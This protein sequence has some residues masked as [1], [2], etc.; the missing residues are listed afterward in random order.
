VKAVDLP[1]DLEED[2]SDVNSSGTAVG[3]SFNDKGEV[4]FVYVNG[5]A[6]KLAGPANGSA[7]AIN[8]AG[9]I[10]G[11][12]SVGGP[13]ATSN[14]L[15]WT[16]PT[17]KPVKLPVPAGV[18]S[19]VAGDIDEDGTTVGHLDLRTPYV[20]FPDGTHRELPMPAYQGRT[21][22]AARAFSIRNGIAIGV[23][24]ATDAGKTGTR[25]AK[26]WGVRWNVRTGETT[27]VDEFDMRPD[28]INA[29]GWMIG[30]DKKGYAILSA[31]AGPIKLPMIAQ[32]EPGNLTN[33]P[34]AI[35][36][37]GRTLV[38]QSDN[39]NGV[40]QPVVWRCR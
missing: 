16:S 9:A 24:D 36:D 23:A 21:A 26:M 39:A 19:A 29:Q 30:I 13:Q 28:A 33:I 35:S 38:G 7:Q 6:R 31:G 37:D 17:A 8:N 3:W 18:R 15:L 32:H 40:I 10:V 14:A 4:P 1:G 12:D 25:D 22:V 11:S 34:N 5:T 20:W 27:I 2:L